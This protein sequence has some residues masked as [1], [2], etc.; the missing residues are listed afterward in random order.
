[1][2]R[3]FGLVDEKIAEADFFLGKLSSSGLDFFAA[4]CYFNAFVAAARSISFSLQAVMA[5]TPEFAD[6][7]KEKQ[8]RL[9][10][11]ELARFFVT[12]RNITQ[13]TGEHPVGGAEMRN[14]SDGSPVVGLKFSSS[15]DYPRAP[16]Q[17]VSVACHAYL[18]LLVEIVLDCYED[19]GAAID[20]E[21]HYT[22]EAFAKR[23]LTI[24]DAEEE[25]MGV[26]GWT[27]APGVPVEARW[28]MLRD[29]IGRCEIDH[30]FEKYTGR[31]RPRP[32]A[33]PMSPN[34]DGG[35]VYIPEGL[36][37]TGHDE[38]DIRRFIE[39][40]RRSNDA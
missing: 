9:R 35:W 32:Q 18:A 28:Q 40:L 19:F 29:G 23:G 2:A 8:T 31:A 13:K 24:D 14:A 34:A 4:R 7:Y 27:E 36:C 12:A 1:M 17:E 20:P 30:L 26:R 6:W 25:L 37:E 5:D 11:D 10:D 38:E 3:S 15:R 21:Q 39:S 22:A 33:P 16:T